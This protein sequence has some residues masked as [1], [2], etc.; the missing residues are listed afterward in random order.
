[1]A[2]DPNIRHGQDRDR[3]NVIQPHELAYWS[4][5]FNV[6]ERELREAIKAV[7]DRVEA[8]KKHLAK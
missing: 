8:V 3:I 1:M 5:T 2:D 4:R 6:Q 7:G